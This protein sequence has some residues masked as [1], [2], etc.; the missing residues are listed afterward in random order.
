MDLQFSN[1]EEKRQHFAE[2]LLLGDG[3]QKFVTTRMTQKE[4]NMIEECKGWLQT[5]RI[6]STVSKQEAHIRLVR[7]GHHFMNLLIAHEDQVHAH[8]ETTPQI[9][10]NP[11]PIVEPKKYTP[12]DVEF[13][14]NNLVS[15]F[16]GNV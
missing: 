4:I 6:G 2:V 3:E 10:Q 13:Y 11:S 12:F 7:M 14:K 8:S 5:S 1:E 16:Q 15:K 9:G